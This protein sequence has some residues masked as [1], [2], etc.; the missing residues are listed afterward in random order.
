MRA[1]ASGPWLG[2]LR[3]TA[4]GTW[5][6]FDVTAGNPGPLPPTNWQRLRLDW[7]QHF[8]SEDGI[9]EVSLV[10]TRRAEGSDPWDPSGLIRLPARTNHD[11][12]LGF[13]LVGTHIVLGVRNLTD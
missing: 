6:G 3:A 13:R 2:W 7:E 11:L 1:A 12:L 9:L 8:F 4:E 10:S 5:Q